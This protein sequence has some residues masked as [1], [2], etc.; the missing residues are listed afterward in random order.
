MP[1]VR[2]PAVG[3]MHR[4]AEGVRRN[5]TRDETLLAFRLYCHTPFGRL[6][7]SNPDIIALAERLGRTP[8]AVGMKACNFASLDP[9]HR[10]RGVSGLGN[11]SALDKQ[12]WEEFQ[13]QPAEIAAEAEATADTWPVTRGSAVDRGDRPSRPA[14]TGDSEVARVVRVRRL[15]RFFRSTVLTSYGGTCALTGLA[16]PEQLVASHI[17]PWSQNEHRRVDPTNGICLNALVDRAF[18]RYLITFDQDLRT[19]LSDRLA[20]LADPPWPLADLD[21]RRLTLPSR[22]L[23]DEAALHHHRTEFSRLHS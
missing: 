6:H 8:S 9:N 3:I 2:R 15:Q 7:R 21:G 18:D 10:D 12:I 4:M 1:V 14:A 17:I 23:P 16:I 19:V 11:T 20:N 5:W 13:R 22:W